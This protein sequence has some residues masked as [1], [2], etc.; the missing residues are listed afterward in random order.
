[1]SSAHC[2]FYVSVVGS[3]RILVCLEVA[4][5][6]LLVFSLYLYHSLSMPLLIVINSQ[7]TLKSCDSLLLTLLHCDI[8]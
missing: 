7:F 6:L 5:L 4:S 8:T 3:F 1:M 2:H